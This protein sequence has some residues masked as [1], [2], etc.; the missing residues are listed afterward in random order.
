M[1]TASKAGKIAGD[2]LDV[3]WGEFLVSPVP[4]EL[5]FNY[6]SHKCAY[7][8]ANLNQPN[9]WADVKKT[10]RLLADYQN[11]ET[12]AALLLKQGYPVLVSNRVDPFA[13]SNYQQSVP[14]LLAMA[15]MG[16]PI[17]F[18]TKGGKGIDEVLRVVPKSCWYISISFWDDAKRKAIEPGAPNIQSRLDLIEQ[19]TNAGHSVNVGVNP[20]VPEWLPDPIP[21]LDAI[22][23]RGAKG[24]WIEHFHINQKQYANLSP[25]EITALDEGILEN[26]L[27]R[28]VDTATFDFLRYTETCAIERGLEVYSIGQPR[29]SNFFA[30]YRECYTKTFPVVQD[31]VN[32]CYDDFEQDPYLLRTFD[33]FCAHMLP[34]LPSGKLCVGHYLGAT[35]HNIFQGSN[36]SNWMTFKQLLGI[37]WNDQRAKQHPVRLSCF[38]YAASKENKQWV[39]WRD[40]H[41]MPTLVFDPQGFPSNYCEVKEV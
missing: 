11:R 30:P 17:A 7:C 9:R 40:E 23:M 34:A 41:N 39:E 26:A 19:L 35:A 1:A 5:S 3:Y 14:I 37:A 6:C 16:I 15:E 28:R 18:Q 12:L 10:M 20:L 2:S 27:R 4:L 13:A 21:L 22:K 25:R 24:V 29:K 31:Y 36:L 33:D 32:A 8:F 38:A